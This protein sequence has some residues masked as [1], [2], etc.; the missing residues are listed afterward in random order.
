MS[1][2]GLSVGVSLA[3]GASSRMGAPKA[4]LRDLRGR[5]FLERT[6]AT[7][8][9]GGCDAV[10][11]V[12]GRHTAEIAESLPPQVL[13]VRNPRWEL[14]QLSSARVGVS[15]ALQLGARRIL[16]H[17]VDQPLIRPADVRAVLDSL[18]RGRCAIAAYRG[19]PG[20]PLGL[21]RSTAVRIHLDRRAKTL[22]EAVE[23]SAGSPLLV[24]ASQGVVRGANTPE[25]LERLGRPPARG[26]SAR[27]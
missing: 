11:V 12:T 9:R 6:A 15:A 14:G 4:L 24:P 8:L 7:L 3:A 5:T 23:R 26:L 21:T 22:R 19:T 2:R 25:E 1:A 18:R 27:G 20:P 10:L 17:P 16:V 13:L